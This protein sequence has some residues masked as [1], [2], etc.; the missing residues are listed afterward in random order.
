MSDS[1]GSLVSRAALAACLHPVA[2][3]ARAPLSSLRHS[4][5]RR[6]RPSSCRGSTSTCR[7]RK[8]AY[9]DP[10]FTWDAHCGG[11]FDLVDYVHGRVTFLADYQAVLGSEFR[12]FD[13][14]QSNYTLEA[15]GSYRVGQTEIVGVLHHVSRHL[16]DRAKRDRRGG[17]RARVRASCGGSTTATT[18]LD[19]RVD[20]RKVIA[21][22]Y[23]DYTWIGDVDLI[24]T[25]PIAPAR[26]RVRPRLR[27]S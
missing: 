16:G 15:I 4:P 18:T 25:P 2:V 6:P 1:I 14:Y 7:R 9:D 11:D 21:R 13:P 3:A 5:R 17:K 23:V 22:A 27:R 8:L 24:V 26:R 12:P 10:R 19:V 20:V